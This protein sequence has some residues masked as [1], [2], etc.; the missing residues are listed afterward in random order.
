MVGLEA[1]SEFDEEG[2]FGCARSKEILV[3]VLMYL[4]Q[5]FLRYVGPLL[6]RRLDDFVCTPLSKRP[7]NFERCD[8]SSPTPV[9]NALAA[10][11]TRW[12]TGAI[13]GV[14]FAPPLVIII[15]ERSEPNR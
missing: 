10:P 14:N 15:F 8:L 2:V 6:Q 3:K 7:V 9:D 1:S 12:C 11:N 5:L 4:G 13:I